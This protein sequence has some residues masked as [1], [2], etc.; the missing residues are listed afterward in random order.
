MTVAGANTISVTPIAGGVT[1]PTGFVS[2]ALTAG[3]RS[4]FAPDVA[5]V[6]TE[7]ELASAAAVFTTNRFAAAPV[8][9]AREALRAAGG[10]VRGVVLNAG[11]ANAG[12]GP[13]GLDDA[14]RMAAAVAAAVGC[15]PE[16]VLPASTGL[17]GT[18]LAVERIESAV[19]GLQLD[20]SPASGLAAAGAIMTTDTRPKQA[21]V[22]VEGAN[23]LSLTVGGMAKGAGMIHP[24]MA[25][26]LAVITTDVDASPALLA[27][28]LALATETSFNQLSVDGDT[29]TN[30]AV[31]LLASGRGAIIEPGSETVPALQAGVAAVAVSLA[32]QIAA[33]G[34]G[35]RTRIDVLAKG[36][37]TDVDA[38]RVAR[39]VAASNLVKAAVHG[40][41][42]NWGRIAS[43]VGQS[44][45]ELDPD[46]LVIGIG[47]Q[48]VYDGAPVVFDRAR[49][50]QELLAEVVE[51]RLDL[52]LGRGAGAAWGCDLSPEYVAINSE[53]PT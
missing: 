1:L 16:L 24:A 3:L 18:R 5:V 2:G 13:G 9:V 27:D 42:P 40:G 30:D 39:A 29:S 28:V 45:V 19:G 26:M 46:R 8:V 49:A 41:D 23:G 14:R 34:E 17:I 52:G 20:A 7:A 32:T 36:A 47:S 31:F 4:G 10:R 51:L 15:D 37:A 6:A 50:R 25:T 53:Y 35:A 48:T 21:A 11:C 33:D 44:G 38:R 43:A 22:R 12:T